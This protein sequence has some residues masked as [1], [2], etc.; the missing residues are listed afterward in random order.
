VQIEYRELDRDVT[1]LGTLVLRQYRAETGEHGH[2][3]LIDGSFLM[4]SHG[5]HSERAMA[6]LAHE[7]LACGRTRLRALVGGLG[8]GHT[9]RATL[10]LPGVDSVDVVEISPKVVLWN[11]RWFAAFNGGAVN[12]PRVM[13]RIGD[14]ARILRTGGPTWDLMLLDVDNGP[15]WLATRSNAGLYDEPGLTLCRTRLTPGGVLAI[16][17]PGPNPTLRT[18]LEQVFAAPSGTALSGET[19]VDEVSTSCEDEPAS[20]IYLA[21]A[22]G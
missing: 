11:R 13:I 2:E 6:E 8:A 12:D 14:L 10:D 1:P 20:T 3:I 5:C 22:P 7:R 9:L 21:V 17:S 4:A 16:W 15:G 18:T 19:L